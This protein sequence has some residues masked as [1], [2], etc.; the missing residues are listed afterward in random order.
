MKKIPAL[1]V[2][3]FAFL[4]CNNSGSDTTHDTTHKSRSDTLMDEV[5]EGHDVAMAKI[6]KVNQAKKSIQQVLDSI[7][8]LPTTV[9]KASVQYRM[10]LDSAFNRLTFAGYAMDKW[11]EEFK[12]D[13]AQGD[14]QKRIEYLESEKTKISNVSNAI[15]TSLQ[16]ADSLIR[17][18]K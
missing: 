7:S 15:F 10:Q 18:K 1:I 4:A 6:S 12:M 3:A 17:L 2:F 16:K 13:S 11:M 8:Q 9:Q 14:E 5:M